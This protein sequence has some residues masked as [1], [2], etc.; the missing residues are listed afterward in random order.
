MAST[1]LLRRPLAL[2]TAA[3]LT[4]E[5]RVRTQVFLAGAGIMVLEMLAGRLLAPR[6]GSTIFTWGSLIGVVM[7][8]LAAGYWLGGRWGDRRPMPGTL[9]LL[10]FGAGVFALLM[11][12]FAP[13]LLAVVAGA[14]PDPRFGPLLASFLLIGPPSLAL[15]AATPVAV[16]L[17]APSPERAGS[18]A[19]NVAGISTVGS[20]LGTFLTVFVLIPSLEVG[21]ILLGVGA[22]LGAAALLHGEQ[23]AAM[24]LVLAGLVVVSP[25]GQAAMVRTLGALQTGITDEVLY[26]KSTPYHELFVTQSR[27]G[28]TRTLLL[29]GNRHSA[30]Y[31]DRPAETPYRYIEFFHLGPLLQP[32]AKRALFIGGGGFS[33]PK[34]FLQA[35][36][37]MEIDVVEV[38]GDVV[39]AARR[40]FAVPE[41]PRLRTHVA[42][43]RLFLGA[44]N[45]TWD[46]I[47][48]DAY[49]R[50]Y[51][52]FHLL[53]AEFLTLVREHLAPGGVVVSNVIGSAEGD[54]SILLRAEARTMK[55]V[56]PWVQAAPT[57]PA[58][59]AFGIQNVMMV[60]ALEPPPGWHDAAERA[61]AMQRE[62]GRDYPGIVANLGAL[63]LRTDDVPM[64]TDAYAPVETLVSPLTLGPYDPEAEYAPP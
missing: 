13:P 45:R 23:R 51:V 53:T 47:V 36:P 10:L 48:L 38:D 31:V 24:A 25:L 16:R 9:S 6:F 20:I 54:T 57:R 35:Y 34:Q 58:L 43:G 61:P 12:L 60:A 64:L 30:M 3:W 33:G 37:G 29:D 1:T 63:T 32:D 55:A 49:G 2:P 4:T 44:T 8:A 62:S 26:H 11:P 52:P 7:T 50:T 28:D 14:V 19:G 27:L 40:F 18:V 17:A 21:L 56:F 15:G 46:V 42:D 22:L 39:E 41:D 59:A 5:R